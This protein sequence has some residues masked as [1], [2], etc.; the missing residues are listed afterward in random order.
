MIVD[1]VSDLHGFLPKLDGGDLLIVC[2]DLTARDEEKEYFEFQEWLE[3]QDYKRMIVISGNHDN[4]IEKHGTIGFPDFDGQKM[5]Y[6]FDSGT[7]FEGLKIWGSPWS[8]TFP[9][10]N[11]HCKAFTVD[12]DAE[13][14]DKF[15]QI[16]QDTDILI[17]HMPP[18]GIYDG[19]YRNDM[20]IEYDCVGSTCLRS[21][22]MEIEPK[23]HCFGHIHE[24]GGKVLD[25]GLT[26]FVNA[27]YVNE[28]Y[29]PTNKPV[30]IVL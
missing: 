26:K 12:T 18:R 21:I 29:K 16:P 8:L 22:S 1:I 2:G 19:I 6:L 10:M 9:R 4:W 24:H 27:S 13:L 17:T 5:E 25:L 23:I 11:P 7:E 20:Y 15:V 14:Y 30:R 28:R 3:H